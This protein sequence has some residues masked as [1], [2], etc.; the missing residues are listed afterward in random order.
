MT[1]LHVGHVTWVVADMK[2]AARRE[3]LRTLKELIATV[4]ERR[5]A[6]DLHLE[7]KQAEKQV[8]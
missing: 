7:L 2:E 4:R 3:D 5:Y 1:V 6:V 8:R